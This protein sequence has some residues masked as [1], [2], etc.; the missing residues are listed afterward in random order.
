[1]ANNSNNSFCQHTIA[2]YKRQYLWIELHVLIEGE[3]NNPFLL[4]ICLV[5]YI[6]LSV[7]LGWYIFFIKIDARTKTKAN[8]SDV[9]YYQNIVLYIFDTSSFMTWLISMMVSP[10]TPAL[11]LPKGNFRAV[12]KIRMSKICF[13]CGVKTIK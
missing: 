4:F 10:F 13:I 8:S 9:T 3:Y 2:K 5:R 11:K 1:M 7:P 6:V 12:F